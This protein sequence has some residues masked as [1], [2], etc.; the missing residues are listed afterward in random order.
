MKKIR[1]FDVVNMVVEEATERFSP[2]R[3][4]NE[5]WYDVL[6][7]YCSIIDKMFEE[8]DGI[9]YEVDVDEE[10]CAVAISMECPLFSVDSKD[11]LFYKLIEHTIAFGFV[12]T[13]DGNIAVKFVF[14]TVWE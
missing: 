5:E 12:A 4:L 14:P 13:S 2:L 3:V 7:Q 11:H 10:S 1:C 6:K 8:N 9:A